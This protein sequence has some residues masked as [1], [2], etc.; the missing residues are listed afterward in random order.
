MTEILPVVYL[1]KR[2]ERRIRRGHPW[3]FSNE[4]DTSRSSLQQF[5]PGDS[6][7]L[8]SA[9]DVTLGS[10]YINPRSLIAVRLL[11]SGNHH[12]LTRSL[13]RRRLAQ[14][15]AL[16]EKLFESPFYRLV[17]GEADA[18]PGLV[19]DRYADVL[20][21]QISTAGM[22]HATDNLVAVLIEMFEPAAIIARN[23]ITSRALEGLDQGIS[24][25]HG[26][27]PPH[28]DILENG[29][30]FRVSPLEGQKT[31]WFYDQRLNRQALRRYAN[32]LR[33]LDLFSYAG[34][35]GVNAALAGAIEVCCVDTS[36][37]ALA[38]TLENAKLNGVDAKVNVV[39]GDAFK[40]LEQLH[41]ERRKFDLVISDPPAL[42]PRRKDREA[43]G[44]A[45]KRLNRQAISLLDKDGF[46]LS[47]SCSFHLEA[48]QLR[49][50]IFVGART[51]GRR[52]QF[53]E[54]GQQGPDHPIR[55]GMAE[56]E[57]LKMFVSRIIS[58]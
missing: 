29:A 54:R 18:L 28:V 35:F 21:L 36:A 22:E 32:G 1:K 8:R 37:T 45:Y 17:H 24:V 46:L 47:A 7:E 20:V 27:P 33:V 57:Y 34:G 55:P 30:R 42:I 13:F 51:E 44:K 19:I 3:V 50:A 53:L 10:G 58:G 25:I 15:S 31:G 40:V 23:D 38:A 14:A 56:S 2:E 49:D 16:R 52:V 12:R 9:D 43:G 11:G 41:S 6:V 39:Q 26:T 4:I 48:N 5:Q